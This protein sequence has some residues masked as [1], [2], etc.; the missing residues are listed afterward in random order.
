[1]V[2]LGED[3]D[4]KEEADGLQLLPHHVSRPSQWTREDSRIP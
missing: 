1:M 3:I 4:G 2:S